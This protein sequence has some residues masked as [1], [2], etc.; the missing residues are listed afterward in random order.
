MHL[1]GIISML[2]LLGMSTQ[3]PLIG[4][5]NPYFDEKNYYEIETISI[6][7][8]IVLEVGGLAFDDTG[9]LGVCT[10]RG[11]LWLISDLNGGAP[12]FNRFAHGLHEPLGL[13]WKDGAFITNQRGELTRIS[14]RDKDGLADFYEAICTWELAGNYHEYSYGPHILPDGEM[15]VTL[16]LGWVGRGASLSKWRGWMVKVDETGK[17]TP[18]ATGMRSPAGFGQNALGDIFYTENQGDWVGSGR[19]THLELGDFAGHPEGLKWSGEPGS[20]SKLSME[21]IDDSRGLSLYEY[22]KE[23]SQIKPPSVWFPHTLMGISTSDITV[24]PEGFGPFSNQLLVGDQ[25][26]SKIMRVYQEKVNDVYQGICFPF[27]E[28]F[29]SGVLRFA[30]GSDK[31]LFV[32][33]TNRGW[34]ST[35][36]EPYGLQRV[37]WS[38]KTPFEIDKVN[39]T[40]DGFAVSFTQPVDRASAANPDSYKLTDFTYKYHHLYG[41]PAINTET[42]TVFKVELSQDGRQAQ[43]FVEGLRQGYICEIKAEGVRDQDQHALLHPVG[44][45]TINEIPGR[46]GDD[47]ERQTDLH[48]MAKPLDIKSSKRL[49]DMP[50]D[51]T[52]GPDQNIIIGTL[53]GMQFD[54]KEISIKAGE[55]IRLELNNPDDMMHNLLI[56]APNSADEVAQ[57]AVDLGLSGQE[58][59]Y[60]PDSDLVLYHTNLLMPNSSD[61]I[62]FSAPETPGEYP[63]VCTFPGHSFIMRGVITVLP[64]Q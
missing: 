60:I 16:N 6:P 35:G 15:L 27:R 1:Q 3:V 26:H 41:S 54:I 17:I 51:W 14:D 18:F 55:K 40:N 8:S 42:R 33:M 39:I 24:I 48:S 59:G 63:F 2:I 29:A 31:S 53:P 25:G 47:M 22:S 34:A 32:G 61:V 9:R 30:W 62:Y 49:T 21:D 46:E 11:E 12:N 43:L 38:G 37:T 56:V 50:V 10:R 44:Y 4:Q 13:A 36:K 52:A 45:Y 23:N 7:D 20:P 64:A 19:M 5:V 28:G 58:K 57:L